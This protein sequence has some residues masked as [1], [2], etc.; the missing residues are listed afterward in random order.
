[1]NPSLVVEDGRCRL[2]CANSAEPGTVSCGVSVFALCACLLVAFE[3]SRIPCLGR[4]SFGMAG[5]TADAHLAGICE[6]LGPNATAF[7]ARV[8]AGALF[9]LFWQ[10]QLCSSF[11]YSQLQLPIRKSSL[12]I[13]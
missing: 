7:Q 8:T 9:F 10:V 11:L 6:R 1:M 13:I 5:A 12:H 4:G 3:Q 2:Y